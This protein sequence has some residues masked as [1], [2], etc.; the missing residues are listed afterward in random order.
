M[1]HEIHFPENIS[2]PELDDYLCRGWYRMGQSIF[3]THIMPFN[4][5]LHTLHWLRIA[6]SKVE[7]GKSQKKILEKNK[8]FDV[9][10]KQYEITAEI[11]NLFT[12]YR[13]SVDF[14]APESVFS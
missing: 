10:I 3:T 8:S 1:I 7:F 5:T 13:D 9:E 2:G 14:N 4:G 11:E 12:L 6:V